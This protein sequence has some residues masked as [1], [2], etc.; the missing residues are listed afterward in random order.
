MAKRLD[1]VAAEGLPVPDGLASRVGIRVGLDGRDARYLLL[2]ALGVVWGWQPLATVL[3]RSLSGSQT[4]SY[5]HIVLMPFLTAY[6]LYMTR[7]SVV[8]NARTQVSAGVVVT[9]A[10]A[11]IVRVAGM[12]VGGA[13]NRL[14]VAMLGVVTMWVGGFVLCYGWRALRSAILPFL[15]LAFMVPLPPKILD[16]VIVFLQLSSAEAT[17]VVFSLIGMPTLREGLRFTLPN[18][19]IEVAKECSGI[20]SSLALMISGLAM[21]HLLLRSPWTR[22]FFLFL[23]VPLAIIKNAFRI[24]LLSWLAVYVDVSF[25][26]GSTLHSSGGIPIFVGSLAI[27]GALAWSLRRCEPRSA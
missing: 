20:R 7:G 6:L 16:A 4:D 9:V 3:S 18:L 15:V 22:G 26:T 24:V 5:S 11:V 1:M 14:S 25:I 13:E 21:A 19:T 23:I 10:G 17:A 12:I 27:L 8:R 2:V